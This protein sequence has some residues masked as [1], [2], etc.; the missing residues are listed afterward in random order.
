MKWGLATAALPIV[1]HSLTASTE[2]SS[3]AEKNG[4]PGGSVVALAS[5]A[6]VFYREDW[7]GAPWMDGEP[8]LFLHGN[9][10]T[11]EVWYGWVPRM[12]QR[13]RLYR[14]DLPGFGRSKVP[15]NFEWSLTNYTKMA[16]EF[17]DAA[18]VQS[19]HIIGAK[20]GGAIAMQFAA[21][22]PQ[23]TRTLVVASGPFSSVD[24]K[25]E[26]NSQQVRLGS[27]ATKEEIAYF[28]KLRDATSPE[29]RHGMGTI[30]SAINLDNLL[31]KITA[32]TLIITSDRSA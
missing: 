22:Y 18:G 15:S 24:P 4:E 6:Q 23:R 31:P 16:A 11:S 9:L 1:A 5:G 25:T 3:T 13:Y 30:I 14:P 27:A 19:A 7:L 12:A 20:T 21:T 29:T 17:L 10:E 8:V 2:G 28:D 32:R 26:S